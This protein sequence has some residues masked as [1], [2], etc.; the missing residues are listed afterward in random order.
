MKYVTAHHHLYLDVRIYDKTDELSYD[1]SQHLPRRLS[2]GPVVVVTDNPPVF[3]SVIRK[4]L[5]KLL[6]EIERQR[7]R[8]LDRQ[9]RAGLDREAARL[10]TARFT[11][12][13]GTRAIDPDVLFMSPHALVEGQPPC[14]TL[15]ITT[16]LSPEQLHTCLTMLD[17]TGLLVVYGEWPTSYDAVI[18]EYRA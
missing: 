2:V 11:A 9:K 17:R 18:S 4:R 14:A 6:Y 7:A 15:Y 5:T 13:L 1:L 8:T 10:R 12:K 3:L 16:L